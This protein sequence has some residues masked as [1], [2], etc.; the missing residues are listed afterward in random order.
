MRIASGLAVRARW[1][2]STPLSAASRASR[3]GEGSP[4]GSAPGRGA[5]IGESAPNKVSTLPP[6]ARVTPR[7][8][9]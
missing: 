6:T 5:S 8:V 4:A 1:S 7:T 2:P 3:S 9:L